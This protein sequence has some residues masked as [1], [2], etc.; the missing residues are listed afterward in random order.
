MHLTSSCEKAEGIIFLY[1]N[2]KK[3]LV[4]ASDRESTGSPG[5]LVF[6]VKKHLSE[7]CYNLFSRINYKLV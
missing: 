7:C 1:V 3:C 6:L 4:A 2:K 5:I